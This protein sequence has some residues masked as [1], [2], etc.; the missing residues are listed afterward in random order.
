M[1]RS[2]LQNEN[3][4]LNEP[5]AHQNPSIESE[6]ESRQERTPSMLCMQFVKRIGYARLAASAHTNYANC[7]ICRRYHV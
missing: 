2:A 4:Q 1:Q 3:F 5:T 7:Q 6:K